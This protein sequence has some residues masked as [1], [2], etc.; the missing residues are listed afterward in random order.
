MPW[1]KPTIDENTA[2]KTST[3]DKICDAE[4]SKDIISLKVFCE[5]ILMGIYIQILIL[6]YQLLYGQGYMQ[7]CR[8]GCIVLC[9]CVPDWRF[10]SCGLVDRAVLLFVYVSLIGDLLHAVL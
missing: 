3:C 10:A 2:K 8:Q 6:I 7:S 9:I 5:C 4:A 1:S